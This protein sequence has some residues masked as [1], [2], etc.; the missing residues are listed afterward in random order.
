M[1]RRAHTRQAAL[2]VGCVCII[3]G[4]LLASTGF[5]LLAFGLGAV[6]VTGAAVAGAIATRS[7]RSL[8]IPLAVATLL[9][10]AFPLMVNLAAWMGRGLHG[11]QD[12]SLSTQT[13]AA[14][15]P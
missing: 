9:F 2:L 15:R 12:E 6:L 8:F 7:V 1:A 10:V 13:P 14:P 11:S 5:G 4:W 3:L